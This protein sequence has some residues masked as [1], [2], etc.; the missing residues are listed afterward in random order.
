MMIVSS[1]LTTLRFHSSDCD[2]SC[3]DET[4]KDSIYCVVT[5]TNVSSIWEDINECDLVIIKSALTPQEAF[6]VQSLGECIRKILPLDLPYYEKRAFAESDELHNNTDYLVSGNVCTFMAGTLQLFAP[7]VAA[8]IS[9][10]AKVAWQAGGWVEESFDSI[11]DPRTMGIRTTEHLSYETTSKLGVHCDCGSNITVVVS[12]SDP[13]EYQGG[14]FRLE[15]NKVQFKPNKLTALVFRSEILHGVDP[16]LSG[17][18]E[19]FATEFWPTTDS[20]LGKIARPDLSDVEQEDLFLERKWAERNNPPS[21]P[22]VQFGFEGPAAEQDHHIT[23]KV[24]R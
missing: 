16:I 21:E 12:L 6:A 15:S 4:N 22:Q 10:I 18:R 7:G 3:N 13:N 11:P 19:T 2:G 24:F 17:K 5:H 8:Q 20:P 9:T 14:Q 1:L 23:G